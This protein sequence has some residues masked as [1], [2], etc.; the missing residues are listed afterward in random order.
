MKRLFFKL[1]ISVFCLVSFT[2]YA[3]KGPTDPA[4]ASTNYVV[5]GAFSFVKNAERFAKFAKTSKNMDA[6][7]AMN[8][9]R[10]LYYVYMF[11]SDNVDEAI[12]KVL[13]VREEHPDLWDAWVFTGNLGAL[14]E[15]TPEKNVVISPAEISEPAE[16]SVIETPVTQEEIIVEESLEEPPVEIVEEVMEEPANIEAKEGY[17]YMYFNTINKKTMKEVRGRV[18]L[19]DPERAKE[20]SLEESHQIVEV[21]DPQN[22]TKRI[23]AST[24]IFGFKEVQ[25]LINLDEPVNDST[26]SFVDVVGDSIIL[27]FELE[28]FKKGDVLVMYNVYFFKDAAVMKPESKYELL[29]LLDM[30]EENDKLKVRIH[31]HTN[32]NASGKIVHLDEEKNYFSLVAEQEEDFGS[33]KKLSQFRAET[34]Q[35]WL[36]DQGVNPERMS[37]R[38]WGGKKMIY[39]KHDTQAHKNVRVEIEIIED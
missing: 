2:S 25:H 16:E 7:F 35:A 19:I 10:N 14:S 17:Y 39:D 9:D 13:K 8:P 28:R 20:L 4:P 33:A 37:V 27:D 26:S 36:V 23:K 15:T 24:Q 38:G 21:K 3:G 12:E 6:A 5:I 30:L 1:Y 18:R 32:G 34:I 29:S 22:G 31:G 11:T